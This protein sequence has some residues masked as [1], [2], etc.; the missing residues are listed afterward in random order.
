MTDGEKVK[1]EEAD[2]AFVL[3][4]EVAKREFL[5]SLWHDGG[6]TPKKTEVCIIEATFENDRGSCFCDYTASTHTPIGWT[7]DYFSN[8]DTLCAVHR[9]CYISDILPEAGNNNE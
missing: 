7:N 4:A 3:G 9:W 1:R 8:G 2:V 5:K 6:K